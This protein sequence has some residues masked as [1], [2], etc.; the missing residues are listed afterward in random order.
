VKA[1]EHT[2]TTDHAEVKGERRRV[3]HA[4]TKP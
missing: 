2:A 1:L 4:R 3:P